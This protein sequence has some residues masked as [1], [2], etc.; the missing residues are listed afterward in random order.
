M[1]STGSA[2]LGACRDGVE[3]PRDYARAVDQIWS[4]ILLAIIVGPFVAALVYGLLHR[5]SGAPKESDT[6]EAEA[7]IQVMK[8]SADLRTGGRGF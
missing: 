4:F 1:S 3:T 2:R 8:D 5:R 6:L 7:M